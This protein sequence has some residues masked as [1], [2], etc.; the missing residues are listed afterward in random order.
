MP[1]GTVHA[2]QIDPVNATP[3]SAAELET[4]VGA[5]KGSLTQAL[6][7]A[8][9]S[10]SKAPIPVITYRDADW[11]PRAARIK[12]LKGVIA[13]TSEQPLGRTRTFAQPLLGSDGEAT[14]EMIEKSNG[15]YVAGDRAG[16]SGLQAQYD[17]RLA[18]ATGI[19]VTAGGDGGAT[20]FEKAATDGDNVDTTLDPR[21]QDAAEKALA[22]ADLKVPGAVVAIDVPTGQ[23]LAVANSPTS[24][25][26][27]ALTG[28]YPPGS[29]FKVTTSY[30][31]LTRGITTRPRRCRARHP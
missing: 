7:K 2:V 16:R 15:R 19:R 31:Y 1:L 20:L 5:A 3:E 30:A 11:K 22:D 17:A 14:A 4:I 21:V 27:R 24:G 6:A 26:D 10:G 18:G 28:R 13:P 29:T 12:D 9:A 23:V 8:R 25:F